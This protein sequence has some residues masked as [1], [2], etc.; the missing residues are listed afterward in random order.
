MMISIEQ[1]IGP[2]VNILLL[3]CAYSVK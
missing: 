1:D 2:I 3:L